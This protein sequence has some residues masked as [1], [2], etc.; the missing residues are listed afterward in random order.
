MKRFGLYPGNRSTGAPHLAARDTPISC[1]GMKHDQRVRLSFK[2]RRKK[3]REPTK[4][5]R[6]SG[7]MG[8][9]QLLVRDVSYRMR[10]SPDPVCALMVGPP[11]FT[12][13]LT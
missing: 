13:P 1:K 6:K 11:P 3:I 7:D 10:I 5:H 4:L 8:H 9:P 12:V 2:E